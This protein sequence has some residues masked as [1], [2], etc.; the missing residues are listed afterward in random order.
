MKKRMKLCALLLALA[1]TLSG[2]VFKGP[3]T[4]AANEVSLPEPQEEPDSMLLGEMLSSSYREVALYYAASDGSGFTTVM[5]GVRADAAESLPEAAVSALLSSTGPGG[6]RTAP[7]A[8][9]TGCEFS[10]GTATVKLSLDTRAVQ[11]AQELLAL[12]ASIGNTLLGIEGVRG[13]NVLIGD[14]SEGFWQLPFGVQTE[15]INSVTAA[16][17]QLQAEHDRKDL[18]GA[19]PVTRR[20]LVYFPTSGG[21]WLV[22]ELRTINATGDRFAAALIDALK[23]GP[24]DVACAVPSIPEGVELLE[25]G[26]SVETLSS[27]E[28]VLALNFSPTLINYLAFSGLDIWELAA[29]LSLTMTSFLPELDAIRIL[30]NGEP[31]TMCMIGSEVIRF[32]D[33]LIRRRHFSE[34]IGST[35][36]LYLIDDADELRGVPRAVSM[37]SALSPRSLLAELFRYAD[38]GEDALRLPISA[39][40]F[41]EDILGVQLSRNIARV[42]LSGAFYRSCQS[43]SPRAERDLVYAIVNTLCGL[44]DIRGVR[45]YIEGHAADTLAGTIYLKSVLL[46]NPGIVAPEAS[47]GTDT[48]A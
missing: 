33:G 45:L 11:S 9:L 34:R 16:Y 15:P 47:E 10:C 12:E 37:H 2:C 35:A 27:G 29:S 39:K 43:L 30:V 36:V 13:V 18:E 3:D 19:S 1:L 32:A 31:I 28:R 38:A 42:N 48:E 20:A 25:E 46:P 8:R 24:R 44:E 40:L 4:E 17:A 14:A 26:L 23:E 41:P 7:D 22:P 21:E 5:R 6:T